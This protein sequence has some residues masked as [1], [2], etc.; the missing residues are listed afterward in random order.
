MVN[1]FQFKNQRFN[2]QNLNGYNVD[3]LNRG[4]VKF[5]AHDRNGYLEDGKYKFTVEYWNDEIRTKSRIL[6]FNDKL[7]TE[8]LKIKD[9]IGA[10]KSAEKELQN[11]R[12]PVMKSQYGQIADLI[13]LNHGG[14]HNKTAK[15]YQVGK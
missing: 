12:I 5:L 11:I 6:N 1:E 7:I 13:S 2:I 14:N 3:S 10:E 9:K 8:Y 4:L 15:K